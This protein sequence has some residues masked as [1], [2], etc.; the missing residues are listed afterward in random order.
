MPQVI[1]TRAYLCAN[2]LAPPYLGSASSAAAAPAVSAS[3]TL[4]GETGGAS[5]EGYGAGMFLF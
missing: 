5:G 2:H 1:I 3:P 4:A